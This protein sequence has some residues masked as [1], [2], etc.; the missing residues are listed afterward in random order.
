[1][2]LPSE[3]F[4][5]DVIEIPVFLWTVILAG[6]P[7]EWLGWLVYGVWSGSIDTGFI[8]LWYMI[9]LPLLILLNAPLYCFVILID[10]A[11]IVLFEYIG[12]FAL[13]AI[14]ALVIYVVSRISGIGEIDDGA[15]MRWFVSI[16]LGLAV[17]LQILSFVLPISKTFD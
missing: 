15:T 2:K 14:F 6:F 13:L 16:P 4:L 1:M 8:P 17:G 11:G 9:V 12:L 7:L 5:F 3:N 10:K